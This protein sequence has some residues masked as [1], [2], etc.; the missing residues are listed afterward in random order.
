MNLAAVQNNFLGLPCNKQKY[1]TVT[2]VFSCHK[3]N[4]SQKNKK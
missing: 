3:A 4:V 1:K 2:Y